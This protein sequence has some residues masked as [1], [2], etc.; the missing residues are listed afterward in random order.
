MQNARNVQGSAANTT[1]INPPQN[2]QNTIKRNKSSQISATQT[3]EEAHNNPVAYFGSNAAILKA[4]ESH[5]GGADKR[6]WYEPLVISGSIA[7]F[8]IYF[9]IL[10]E[11]NDI[12]EKLEGNLFDHVVGLE[13]TQLKLSLNYNREHGLP[14]AA[15]E[16]R[17]AEVQARD[18]KTVELN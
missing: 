11:E 4:A 2:K 10:R 5:S 14:V 9:C 8:M 1:G 17:L 3:E 16:A 18:A 13:A 12:D 7:I 6:L 15:L